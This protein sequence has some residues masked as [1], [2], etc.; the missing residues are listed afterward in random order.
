ML[1]SWQISLIQHAYILMCRIS[2]VVGKACIKMW[3]TKIHTQLQT[4]L[5]GVKKTIKETGTKKE[6]TYRSE[7]IECVVCNASQVKILYRI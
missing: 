4:S 3:A 7:W 6:R 1:V 2:Y 5:Y